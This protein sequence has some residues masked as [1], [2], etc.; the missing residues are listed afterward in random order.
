M[1]LP[2]NRENFVR[3]ERRIRPCE[4]LYFQIFPYLISVLIIVKFDMVE[5]MIDL[6]AKFLRHRCNMSP[7]LTIDL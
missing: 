2:T 4:R 1:D 6:Y 5:S 3:I 7:N